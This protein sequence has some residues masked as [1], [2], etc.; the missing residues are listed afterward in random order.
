MGSVTHHRQREAHQHHGSVVQHHQELLVQIASR[1]GPGAPRGSGPGFIPS[2]S[3][4]LVFVPVTEEHGVDVVDEVG[5]CELR[6]SRGKPVSVG[7]KKGVL[8]GAGDG[9]SSC[10]VRGSV[11]D[12]SRESECN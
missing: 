5:H 7:Q 10:L 4:D 11:V 2:V 1:H 12:A 3:F 9:Q 6:V 8:R